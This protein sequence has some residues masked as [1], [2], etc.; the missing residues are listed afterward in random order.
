MLA[1]L[2][3]SGSLETVERCRDLGYTAFKLKIGFGD[4][5]DLRN[6]KAIADSLSDSEQMMTDANQGWS[7]EKTIEI[8][9]KLAA[10]PL[11]W[12][13]EPIIAYLT[14]QRLGK[15]SVSFFHPACSR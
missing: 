11:K 8:L 14:G 13:E 4:D 15:N 2:I 3:P 7:V 1:A 6:L 5:T 12:L 10:F 9:P